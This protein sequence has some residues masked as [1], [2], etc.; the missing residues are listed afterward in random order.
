MKDRSEM[1]NYLKYEF[2]KQPPPLFD[3]GILRKGNKSALGN[4]S[5]AKS[6]VHSELP[7][8]AFFV[9]DGGHLLH[10]VPWPVDG[11]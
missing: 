5:K 4:I 9:L 3:K 6:L 7:G 10:V 2:A 11:T 8:D 1:K